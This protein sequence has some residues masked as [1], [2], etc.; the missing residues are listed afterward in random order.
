MMY[1][2]DHA[3]NPEFIDK[4]LENGHMTPE[5]H[6]FL[7][8]PDFETPDLI[9]HECGIP[10]IH[11]PKEALAALPEHIKKKMHVVHCSEGSVPEGLKR[12]KCGLAHTLVVEGVK[13]PIIASM[14]RILTLL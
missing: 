14:H 11:T 12:P 6:N 9:L 7:R 2:A 13:V 4:L 3:Y 5:R 10:P 8:H 1:S